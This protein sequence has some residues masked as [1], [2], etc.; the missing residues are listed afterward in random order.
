MVNRKIF[1]II[2]SEETPEDLFPVC[3]TVSYI[4]RDVGSTFEGKDRI[5]D[6][7]VRVRRKE[8]EGG[9]DQ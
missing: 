3:E 8:K 4:P 6:G 9:R 1:V 7:K 5:N 2:S